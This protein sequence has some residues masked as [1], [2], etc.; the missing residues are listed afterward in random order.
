MSMSMFRKITK[1]DVSETP[2]KTL[3]HQESIMAD[4]KEPTTF[5]SLATLINKDQNSK[6]KGIL[7]KAKKPQ[8]PHAI[9]NPLNFG[10][11]SARSNSKV[12]AGALNSQDEV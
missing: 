5:K 2:V 7:V 3:K 12:N 4:G 1:K 9:V 11:I 8:G 10:A 6:D